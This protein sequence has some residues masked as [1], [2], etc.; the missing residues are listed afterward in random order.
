MV[1]A[2]PYTTERLSQCGID[3]ALLN[4]ADLRNEADTDD[5]EVSCALL[6]VPLAAGGFEEGAQLKKNTVVAFEWRAQAQHVDVQATTQVRCD[7]AIRRGV[8]IPNALRAGLR[9][10]YTVEKM[11]SIGIESARKAYASLFRETKVADFALTCEYFGTQQG[12]PH[13]ALTPKTNVAYAW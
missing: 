3:S 6:G 11:T 8:A 10:V 12:V 1:R 2:Q 7:S 13:G 4:Q 9:C 5:L